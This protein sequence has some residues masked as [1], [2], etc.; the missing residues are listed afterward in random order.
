[1]LTHQ[2]SRVSRAKLDE[3]FHLCVKPSGDNYTLMVNRKNKQEYE[4]DYIVSGVI[5]EMNLNEV[6][7]GFVL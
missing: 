7:V 6:F 2:M 3:D 5:S 1:M 4:H